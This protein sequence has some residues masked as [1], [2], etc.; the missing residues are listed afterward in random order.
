M[1]YITK[2]LITDMINFMEDNDIKVITF[3]NCTIFCNSNKDYINENYTPYRYALHYT[4]PFIT[5]QDLDCMT[6]LDWRRK[7]KRVIVA[8]NKEQFFKNLSISKIY[9]KS[10]YDNLNEIKNIFK[11]SKNKL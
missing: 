6:A 9:G 1:K 2:K 3:C 7:K 4:N 10:I 11:N 8:D 5:I